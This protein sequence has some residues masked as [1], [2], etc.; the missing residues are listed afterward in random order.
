MAMYHY[1]R[2][3][4]DNVW[5]RN[6]YRIE[7]LGE[8]GESVVVENVEQLERTIARHLVDQSRPL[9]GQEFRFLRTMMDMTQS[10]I[11]RRLGKDYQSVARWETD[12]RKPVPKFADAAIRQ[13]YLESIG[14]RPL[15]TE[16]EDR[17]AELAKES[18][19]KPVQPKISFEEDPDGRWH[20][21][22]A[23]ELAHGFT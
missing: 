2:C 23:R 14:E 21:Q 8:Y 15:F 4:L 13:R 9:T 10:A 3:G 17:L 20:E 6:G 12:T 22:D 7:D 5:L 1:T 11:G 16:I 18:R 19:V